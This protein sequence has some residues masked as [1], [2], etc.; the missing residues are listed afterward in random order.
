ME[1]EVSRALLFIGRSHRELGNEARAVEVYEEAIK[2]DPK[3]FHAMSDI[4]R[5]YLERGNFSDAVK[6]AKR[7]FRV[8]PKFLTP[9]AIQIIIALLTK[10]TD[11]IELLIK[12]IKGDRHS[13]LKEHTAGLLKHIGETE[14]N[15]KLDLAF[16]NA[17]KDKVDK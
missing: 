4:A 7:S 16:K 6:W 15:R 5:I 1:Y 12:K 10:K 8:N 2:K 17:T 11:E 9:I 14:Y 3:L 13:D